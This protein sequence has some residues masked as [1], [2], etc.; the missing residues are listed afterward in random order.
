MITN[1]NYTFICFESRRWRGVLDTTLCDKVS[2][3][4]TAS[5]WFS[6]GT[7]VFSTNKT[8]RH[9]INEILL[10]VAL[11]TIALIP[12]SRFFSPLYSL[13][14]MKIYA[15]VVILNFKNVCLSVLFRVCGSF[16][17]CFSLHDFIEITTTTQINRKQ[18][19]IGTP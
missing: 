3:W 16:F 7:P 15:S 11:N 12:L 17:V 2:Q 1:I 10:K 18:I 8:D 9:D 6:P 5:R 14:E 4:L 13:N 19:A